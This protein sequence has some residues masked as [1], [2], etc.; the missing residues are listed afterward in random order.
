VD[1]G[2]EIREGPGEAEIGAQQPSLVFS[3]LVL[4]GLALLVVAGLLFLAMRT[5]G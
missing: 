5:A 2:E 1:E 3:W 4:A